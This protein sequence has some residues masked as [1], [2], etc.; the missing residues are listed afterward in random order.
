[1]S[2]FKYIF[3]IEI[4][5]TLSLYGFTKLNKVVRVLILSDLAL[6]F[7]WGLVTPILAIFILENIEGGNAKVAGI[8]IGIYWL[9]KSFLQIPIA[10]YLDQN[11]G[12]KD[13][14]YALVGGTL[15]ASLSSL[16]FLVAHFPW[17]VY[18]IQIL[19]ALGMALAIPAWSA[20]FTRHIDKGKEA[21]SWSFDSS[22]LGICTGVAGILGG[23][24]AKGLGFTL[25][26]VAVSISGIISTLLF[27]VIREDLIPKTEK[28]QFYPLVKPH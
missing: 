12:E 17:H 14:Y 20:I 25:L 1:M 16:G 15:L 21:L 9:L 27:L 18:A 7:G 2:K 8:A 22:A 23:M 6:L 26:F 11:R 13:D 3:T 28:S 4:M 24:I 10:Q 19:H 5:R